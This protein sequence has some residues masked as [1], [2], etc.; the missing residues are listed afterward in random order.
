[1]FK[2]RVFELIDEKLEEIETPRPQ[3]IPTKW[4]DQHN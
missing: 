2:S 3:E 1:M 4:A